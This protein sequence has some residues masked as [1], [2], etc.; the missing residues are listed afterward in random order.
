[1]N[2]MTWLKK[3]RMEKLPDALEPSRRSVLRREMQRSQRDCRS[4]ASGA[5]GTAA[6]RKTWRNRRTADSARHRRGVF[7]WTRSSGRST[8][9]AAATT[10]HMSPDRRPRQAP[11]RTAHRQPISHS[12]RVDGAMVGERPSTTGQPTVCQ[13]I[14]ATISSRLSPGSIPGAAAFT[15]SYSN[16][17][18]IMTFFREPRPTGTDLQNR[19]RRRPSRIRPTPCTSRAQARRRTRQVHSGRGRPSQMCR[20]SRLV[21]WRR[22]RN[23]PLSRRTGRCT[24]R[25]LPARS[26]RRSGCSPSSYPDL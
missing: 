20:R 8:S 1:M 3:R 12:A 21:S 19:R 13:R 11:A 6:R 18:A 5:I 10:P 26:R 23:R 25:A 2:R 17:G 22:P 9:T 7:R 4:G 14:A 15:N 24:S 16:C